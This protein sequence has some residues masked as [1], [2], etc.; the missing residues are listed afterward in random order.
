MRRKAILLAGFV[1][2][3]TGVS[4]PGFAADGATGPVVP[5]LP[6]A[7]QE[8]PPQYGAKI[9]D[10]MASAPRPDSFLSQPRSPLAAPSLQ[11]G[12]PAV[13]NPFETHS[14]NLP[15]VLRLMEANG[16]KMTSLGDE[17]G[18]HGYLL[19]ESGGRMQVVYLTPDGKSMVV[20]VMQALGP[21]GKHFENVTMLQFAALRERFEAARRTIEE[22]KRAADEARKRADAATASLLD[23]QR[24]MGE[25]SR[26][27]SGTM[28][29]KSINYNS[30][31]PSQPVSEPAQPAEPAQPQ[32]ASQERA[33]APA[34][35]AATPAAPPREIAITPTPDGSGAAAN[36]MPPQ[37]APAKPDI[38]GAAT[39][40]STLPAP[41][42]LKTAS[43]DAASP[44]PAEPATA[45][46]A[47][48]SSWPPTVA[49]MTARST[50][51]PQTDETATPAAPVASNPAS[52]FVSNIDK[53]KLL[54]NIERTA[55]F[56]VGREGLPTVYMIA[57]PQC[58]HCHAAWKALK[59]LVASGKIAVKVLL[60]SALPGS[61]PV[62]LNLISQPN[63]GRAWWS[64]EG[65]EE[66]HAVS[67]GAPMGSE[68]ARKAQHYLDIN[69]DFA[70][71]YGVTGTPWMVY[72][73]HD[74]AVYQMSGD[75][76]VPEFVSAIN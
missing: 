75:Q 33:P 56:P 3:A 45:P 43:A 71:N 46:H 66:G 20:G 37:M 64:G 50:V 18:L 51:G 22:Q 2:F 58:P 52:R 44:K 49:Q 59:P 28:D 30:Q 23:Q 5:A 74:G 32:A 39:P 57:D 40:P 67:P 34:A 12:V 17:G 65:S 7:T 41:A 47:Q 27:F 11:Q 14:A 9:P 68:D 16:I 60:I 26:Q 38:S 36:Q 10:G 35:D 53:A 1:V 13:S 70:R 31:Q 55:Y 73:G 6:A 25:A 62:A 19:E 42:P 24:Q 69:M 54:Y 29:G 15:P 8:Q 72:I 4:H 61:N 76:D 21:D 63:P 48:T